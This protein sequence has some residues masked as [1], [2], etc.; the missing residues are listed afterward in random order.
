MKSLRSTLG[1]SLL[2]PKVAV[3]KK[4][5][6]VELVEAA[7]QR[8]HEP[9]TTNTTKRITID[10]PMDIYPALKSHVFKE[11]L[12]LKDYLLRLVQLDLDL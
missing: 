1:E 4:E 3:G 2:S 5:K 12:T 6:N 8:I 10:V 9:I 7:T 11:G